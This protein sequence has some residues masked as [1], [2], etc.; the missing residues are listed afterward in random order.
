MARTLSASSYLAQPFDS[1]LGSPGMVRI[2][3]ALVRHGGQLPAARL[4]RDTKLTL[5]GVIKVLNHLE[6]L[7]VVNVAGSGRTRLYQPADHHPLMGMLEVLFRSEAV[8][9]DRVLD[10]VTKAGRGLGLSALWLFGSA[11]RFEDRPDSDLDILMVSGAPDI[12]SHERSADTLRQRL[13]EAAELTG[14]R[15][16]VIALT[17]DDLKALIDTRHS[18]WVAAEHDAK[19]LLGQS[20]RA[21]A[22]RF[23]PATV[24][25]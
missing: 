23:G 1:V 10:A 22:L 12:A 16:S 17:M 20:P 15:P 21:L 6:S 19:V 8:Y 18:V 2:L 25:G 3:R 11:A 24:A 9:R 14:L 7:G 5:P 4:V 13:A